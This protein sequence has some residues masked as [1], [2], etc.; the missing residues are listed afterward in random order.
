MPYST[1]TSL[2][3]TGADGLYTIA[4]KATTNAG[5]VG[6]YTKQVRLDRTGPTITSS[7]TA[8]TNA[9]WYDVSQKIT[10]T[11]SGTDTD[12]VASIGATLDG[13]TA[14][15]TG[16]VINA[17]TLSAGTHTVVITATDGVGNVSTTT[18]T[19]TV[20]ATVGGLTTAVNDGVTAAKITSS[21][22]SSQLLSYL[23]SAQAALTANNHVS[24]K[25]YLASFVS[26]DQAQSGLTVNAAYSALLAGWANELISRL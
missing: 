1:T 18:I 22:T 24:A 14:V 21:T 8:P 16:G 3:L 23:S 26:L 13:T 19:I 25:S 10:L 12:N 9:G 11:Y 17:E 7:A 20:H 6:T 4:I 2:A 15:A 5:Y